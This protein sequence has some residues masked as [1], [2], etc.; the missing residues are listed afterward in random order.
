MEQHVVQQVLE[1]L[2]FVHVELV[3]QVQLVK[4][5]SLFIMI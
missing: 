1:A 3:I 5:V 4:F 2:I